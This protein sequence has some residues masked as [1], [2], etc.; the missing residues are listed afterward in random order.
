MQQQKA[1]RLSPFSKEFWI[2]K[3][4]SEEEA[5]YKRNSIR[6]IRKEYWLEKGFSEE[7][8]IQKA[9]DTKQSNNKKGAKKSAE[10]PKSEIRK[11]NRRC[12]EYWIER[13]FSEKEAVSKVSEVQSTF[14]LEKNIEKYGLVEGTKRWNDRQAKW[15][16]TLQSKPENEKQRIN[17]SK[18][19]ICIK[20]F[21]S[22]DECIEN[23]SRTRNM[24]LFKTFEGFIDHLVNKIFVEKPHFQYMPVDHYLE[25]YV[26]KIQKSI[27]REL[28]PDDCITEKISHLFEKAGD[29]FPPQKPKQTYRQWTD[30]GYLRSSYE[31]YFYHKLKEKFPDI[32]VTSNDNYPN[33]SFRFDFFINESVYIEICP[34][35]DFDDK[36]RKKMD[37]K[38]ALFGCVL[39]KT[40][41]EIDDFIQN[42]VKDYVPHLL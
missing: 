29:I 4:F 15:Q 9:Y 40:I 23:L 3:G 34:N 2:N 13:G 14:S 33:S 32:L 24:I 35:Y 20:H 8:A 25:N 38:S 16:K 28:Y 18:N 27:F 19:A 17:K 10:R 39:L 1:K 21:S 22:I 36:Y 5:E 31:I 30:D 12:K 37:K 26:S 7:E 11:V 42:K 6:P 41:E